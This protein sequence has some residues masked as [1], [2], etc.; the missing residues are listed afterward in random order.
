MRVDV[1]VCVKFKLCL[2]FVSL[3]LFVLLVIIIISP[4]ELTQINLFS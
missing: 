1:S 3:N 2:K 4:L